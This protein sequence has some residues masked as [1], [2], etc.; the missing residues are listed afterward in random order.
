[1]F[2]QLRGPA[3]RRFYSPASAFLPSQSHRCQAKSR[4][5]TGPDQR[6][7]VH[8]QLILP[9]TDAAHETLEITWEVVKLSF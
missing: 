1:M 3:C 8:W 6:R 5:R 7:E 4:L 9:L 2:S